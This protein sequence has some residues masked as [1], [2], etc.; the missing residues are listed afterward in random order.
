MGLQPTIFNLSIAMQV[1]TNRE[2]LVMILD[3]HKTN[4]LVQ[5]VLLQQVM[6][7]LHMMLTFANLALLNTTKLVICVAFALPVEVEQDRQLLV[8]HRLIV[9]VLK[10]YVPA[11][12]VLKLLELLARHMVVIFVFLA[13]FTITNR[14]TNAQHVPLL[15]AVVLNLQLVQQQQIELV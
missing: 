9:F 15:V 1:I 10:T 2:L 6:H 3:V 13:Y 8:L 14:V 7:V 12:M 11:I 5:M 4:V